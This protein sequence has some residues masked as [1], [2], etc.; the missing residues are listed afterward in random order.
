[1]QTLKEYYNDPETIR[2]LIVSFQS[3]T[4]YELKNAGKNKKIIP[5]FIDSFLDNAEYI[6]E[7]S[8]SLTFKELMRMMSD[9]RTDPRFSDLDGIPSYT[10]EENLLYLENLMCRYLNGVYNESYVI[11]RFLMIPVKGFF[12]C[13]LGR[14]NSK[15]ERCVLDFYAKLKKEAGTK[16]EDLT[17]L[18]I[19]KE[20]KS[21]MDKS[22]IPTC[23][24]LE[25]YSERIIHACKI[26]DVI[27]VEPLI[28][29]IQG[30]DRA[31]RHSHG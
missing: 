18:D 4:L 27:F 28:F 3:M 22:W 9:S 8:D 25:D 21:E 30:P 5:T 29:L 10:S 20:C 2:R 17:L 11:K 15:A 16:P 1:M 14:A 24:T 12:Q 19:L 31:E 7:L 23:T 6:P 13:V 26:F